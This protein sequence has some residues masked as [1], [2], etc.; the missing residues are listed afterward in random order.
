MAEG[1][2]LNHQIKAALKADRIERTRRTGEALMGSLTS[3]NV[4]EAW[5]TL[6][7]WYHKAEENAPKPCCDTMEA[8]IK[9]REKLYDQVPPPGD[10]IPSYI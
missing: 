10:K 1:R 4:K 9:E 6:W 2:R 5:R 3:V 8:Q 7:R